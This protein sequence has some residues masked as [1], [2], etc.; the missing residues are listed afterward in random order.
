MNIFREIRKMKSKS[1]PIR[2][3][4]I[5]VFLTML[6]ISTFA[7]FATDKNIKLK[8]LEGQVTSWDV[9]YYVNEDEN[10]ILDRTA[11]F[12]VD[13]FY[14]GMPIREDVVHIY[15]I[16]TTSTKIKYEII[17]VKIFGEEVLSSLQENGEISTTIEAVTE[18]NSGAW[19]T[20]ENVTKTELFAKETTYPF[21]VS[22]TY[23]KDYLQGKW[24]DR[25]TTPNAEATLR[26]NVNWDYGETGRSDDISNKDNLD[27]G[28]G[29]DAY[30]YYKN[31]GEQSSALEIK[32]R[33]TSSMFREDLEAE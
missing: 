19:P 24:V 30:E 4:S 26:F 10:E 18:D 25:N 7:W 14:P 32:I 27:T 17:S 2:I 3:L 1:M 16:G 9:A 12:V 21:N 23:D 29:K 8:G 28:I 15:N 11:T 22:Y 5:L 20:T 13:E 33:I 31:G 6:I